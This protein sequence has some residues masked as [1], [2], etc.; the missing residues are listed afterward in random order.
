MPR[1]T[2]QAAVSVSLG[3]EEVIRFVSD[4]RNRS[5]YLQT[6]KSVSN[7]EGTPGEVTRRWNWKWEWMGQEFE[8]TGKTVDFEPC[9]HYSFVTEG[10]IESHFTYRAEAENEGTRLS[11]DVD[12]EVPQAFVD[13]K[14]LE[15]LLTITRVRAQESAWNL[16]RLMEAASE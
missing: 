11:I 1:K 14:D 3:P 7:I 5:K 9:Q 8:G 16:K 10:G 13:R 12:F 4:I 6:L 15:G 2:I